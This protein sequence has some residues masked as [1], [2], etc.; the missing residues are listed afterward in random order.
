MGGTQINL[1]VLS[2]KDVLDAYEDPSRHPELVVR[3]TGF[4]AYFGSLSPAMRKFVVDR[5]ISEGKAS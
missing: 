5:I 2:V 1:N 3:V 4:S